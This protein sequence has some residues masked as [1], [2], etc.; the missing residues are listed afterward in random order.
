MAVMSLYMAEAELLAELELAIQLVV[1]LVHVLQ[2]VR[3]QG[4]QEWMRKIGVDHNS[5]LLQRQRPRFFSPYPQNIRATHG[6]RRTS[7]TAPAM[8]RN[9]SPGAIPHVSQLRTS[10]RGAQRLGYQG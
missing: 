5:W 10:R 1:V 6:H 2:E 9:H 4:R 3:S 7:R 8:V